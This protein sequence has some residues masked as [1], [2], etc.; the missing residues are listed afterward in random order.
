MIGQHALI[1]V[2]ALDAL[3]HVARVSEWN[4]HES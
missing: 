1:A 2:A 4:P 3:A